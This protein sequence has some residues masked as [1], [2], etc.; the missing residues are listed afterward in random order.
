MKKSFIF[1]LL[2]FLFIFISVNVVYASSYSSTFGF[3]GKVLM[4]KI[5]GVTCDEE[6]FG[7]IELSSNVQGA[8]DA[9]T[10]VA[11]GNNSTGQKIT[12][13]VSGIYKMIPFFATNTKKQPKKGGWIIGK[14]DI[15]PNFKICYLGSK[16]VNANGQVVTKKIPYPVRKT[17]IYNVSG[18]TASAG[19]SQ[20]GT[21]GYSTNTSGGTINY[22]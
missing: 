21:A 3:G 14:A 10:S 19:A 22:E 15:A 18:G 17:S 12:G 11:S 6:G 2:A 9:T 20:S 4:D 8:I 5:P 16:Y 1:L 13:A 7:P